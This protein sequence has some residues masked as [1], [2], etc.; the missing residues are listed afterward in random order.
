[1]SEKM[2]TEDSR[3]NI[4]IELGSQYAFATPTWAG[5]EREFQPTRAIFIQ[6]VFIEVAI[7]KQALF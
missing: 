3:G 6:Q 1:M 5:S 7:M 2:L 4:A